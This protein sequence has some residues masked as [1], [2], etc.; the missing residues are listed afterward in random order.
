MSTPIADQYNFGNFTTEDLDLSLKAALA[1]VKEGHQRAHAGFLAIEQAMA[2]L[3]GETQYTTIKAIGDELRSI[4]T[5]KEDAIGVKG[6]AFNKNF[7][8]TVGTVAKGDHSHTHGDV[9]AL[10]AGNVSVE[11]NSAEKIEGIIKNLTYSEELVLIKDLAG[12]SGTFLHSDLDI[13]TEIIVTA[14]GTSAGE[15]FSVRKDVAIFKQ[16]L[17]NFK[18]IIR[19]DDQA[20][21]DYARLT[22]DGTTVT[23]TNVTGIGIYKI[24]GVKKTIS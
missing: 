10:E 7:G 4:L 15:K 17:T 23:V 14:T 21:N 2:K 13:Y 6:D 18:I 19:D 12:V 22:T 11:Y 16:N 8:T 3:D 24:Y 9:G 1:Q 5:G 20:N